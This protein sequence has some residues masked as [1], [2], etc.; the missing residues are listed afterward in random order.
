VAVYRRTTRPRFTLLL[1]VLTSITIITLDF[2]GAGGGVIESIKNGAAD[3]F[4]PVQSTADSVLEPVGNFFQGMF[5]YGDLEAENERLREALAKSE[6]D[7]LRAEDARRELRQLHELENLDFVDNIPTVSARVVTTSASNFDLT[8]EIDRGTG[9]GIAKGMP[10]VTGAGLVGRVVSVSDRRA[11]VLLV[12]DPSS[13]V[14]IR[15]TTSGDVGVATGRGAGRTLTVD[16]IALDTEVKKGEVVVTSGLQQSVFPPSIPVGKVETA[17]NREGEF[18]KEV[19]IRPVVDL[20]RLAFVK[21]L[22]WSP[23]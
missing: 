10:V 3:A 11:T 5:N 22:Q 16:S 21:V 7:Q 8:I 14:G 17:I 23:Q 19:R 13:S 2:R 18:E 4:A 12:T 15:L 6:G 9:A 1:L 20:R